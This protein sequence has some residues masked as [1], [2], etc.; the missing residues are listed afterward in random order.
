VTNLASGLFGGPEWDPEG[1]RAAYD[2]NFIAAETYSVLSN[3]PG[4]KVLAD[5]LEQ[6]GLIPYPG[7]S[8]LGLTSIDGKKGKAKVTNLIGILRMVYAEIQKEASIS[9]IDP[10]QLQRYAVYASELRVLIQRWEQPRAPE[11][12]SGKPQV[13][14]AS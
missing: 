11:Q 5:N 2:L 12:G 1:N 13:L 4:R 3:I 8:W 9:L 14:P 10:E 7:A 6:G